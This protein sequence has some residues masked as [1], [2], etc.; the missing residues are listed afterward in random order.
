MFEKRTTPF[1][2]TVRKIWWISSLTGSAG[3]GAVRSGTGEVI[4][5]RTP[6]S[7]TQEFGVRPPIPSPVPERT[8]P[9]PAE[10]VKEETHQIF[11][12]VGPN[13]VVR[14]SNIEPAN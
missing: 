4:G 12:T 13:G 6:N 3:A 14:F 1:G 10:P 7:A 8:A 5:G 9:A 11:R 2:P